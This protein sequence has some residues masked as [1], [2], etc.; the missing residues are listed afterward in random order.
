MTYN[1]GWRQANYTIRAF[2]IG[3]DL[4]YMGPMILWNLNFANEFSV[5]QRQEIAA[6][7]ILMPNTVPQERPLYWLLHFATGAG[8]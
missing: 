8:E 4:P 6:Y 7:S 5:A 2:D 3:Q 1:D